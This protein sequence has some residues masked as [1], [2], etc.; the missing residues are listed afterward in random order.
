MT[1]RE[2]IGYAVVTRNAM[3]GLHRPA[4]I[5]A[6]LAEAEN[7]KAIANGTWSARSTVYELR[8]VQAR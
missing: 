8:E 4:T 1:Y 2:P 3:G 6:T 7:A 5:W